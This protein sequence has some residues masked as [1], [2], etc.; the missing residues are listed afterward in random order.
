M[1]AAPAPDPETHAR[2]AAAAA[3]IARGHVEWINEGE[4]KAQ[5]DGPVYRH[6]EGIAI[7]IILRVLQEHENAALNRVFVRR[8][9]GAG[10]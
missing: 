7:P 5:I 8:P 10:R 3:E 2:A 6:L 9:D 4:H 1:T